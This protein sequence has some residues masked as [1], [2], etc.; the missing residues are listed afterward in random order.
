MERFKEWLAIKLAWK[1][2][3]RLVMWCAYRVGSHATMGQW[4]HE[5]PCELKFMTAVERWGH[6]PRKHK[7]AGK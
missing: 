2:P 5:S 7:E 1:L 3:H 4:E 6:E